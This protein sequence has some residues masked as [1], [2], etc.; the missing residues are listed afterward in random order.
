[1]KI[2]IY[3]DHQPDIEILKTVSNFLH[4]ILYPTKLIYAM[5]LIIYYKIFS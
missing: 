4:N 3:N 2:L 1:M 5:L